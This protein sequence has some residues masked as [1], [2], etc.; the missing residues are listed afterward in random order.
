MSV[1]H[2]RQ[3][4][5]FASDYP[6]R[7]QTWAHFQLPFYCI[8]CQRK[9]PTRYLTPNFGPFCKEC[10]MQISIAKLP[11][12]QQERAMT[13]VDE[14]REKYPSVLVEGHLLHVCFIFDEW[15]VWLNTED[16]EF[17]GLCVAVGATR[18]EAVE[19][20]VKV[21]EAVVERLQGPTL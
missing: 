15:Q 1:S 9:R 18:D 2:F 6:E 19:S 3:I 10:L 17:T 13:D 5:I 7:A 16:A 20:A 8:N 21:L 11:E 14:A 12:D 4:P